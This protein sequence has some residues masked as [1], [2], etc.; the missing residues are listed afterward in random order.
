MTPGEMLSEIRSDNWL[1][2]NSAAMIP[3]LKTL[4]PLIYAPPLRGSFQLNSM[5]VADAA[6]FVGIATLYGCWATNAV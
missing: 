2:L 5:N 4:Y 3:F 1:G 6:F